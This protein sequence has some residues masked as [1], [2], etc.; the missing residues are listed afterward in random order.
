MTPSGKADP[1]GG[2]PISG[3]HQREHR[4]T[5]TVGHEMAIGPLPPILPAGVDAVIVSGTFAGVDVPVYPEGTTA[6]M[7]EMRSRA[8]K[9]AYADVE[10]PRRE[11]ALYSDAPRRW[12]T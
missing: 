12:I 6:L 3:G 5:M 7:K 8:C 4:A 2:G 11:I 1:V 10:I 9:I